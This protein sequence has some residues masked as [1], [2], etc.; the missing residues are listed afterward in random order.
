MENRDGTIVL[1]FK[2]STERDQMKDIK[3]LV[4]TLSGKKQ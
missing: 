1:V 2:M 4:N 3:E